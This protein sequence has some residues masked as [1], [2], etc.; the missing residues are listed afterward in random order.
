MANKLYIFIYFIYINLNLLLKMMRL[1]D[2]LLS[3]HQSLCMT[4][5][6]ISLSL[7]IEGSL[8]CE[9]ILF[10]KCFFSF[11]FS[12]AKQMHDFGY[13]SN[14]KM[15]CPHHCPMSDFANRFL[16]NT[17]NKTIPESPPTRNSFLLNQK[18]NLQLFPRDA[19]QF[20]SR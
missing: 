14:I 18:H 6:D 2:F 7:S 8:A 17:E 11:F 16:L 3:G 19:T 10:Q 5:F 9:D 15:M 4:E 1:R 20:M 13:M 12:P